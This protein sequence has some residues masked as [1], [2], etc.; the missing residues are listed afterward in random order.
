MFD[1][2]GLH[3]FPSRSVFKFLQRNKSDLPDS[4]SRQTNTAKWQINKQLVNSDFTVLEKITYFTSQPIN[5]HIIKLKTSYL[6][7]E[8]T[9]RVI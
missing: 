5:Q 3:P 1:K 4:L 6:P 7:G 9:W 2:Q 8:N